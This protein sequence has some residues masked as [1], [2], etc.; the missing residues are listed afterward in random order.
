MANPTS[1]L[2]KSTSRALPWSA[3]SSEVHVLFSS[4]GDSSRPQQTNRHQHA[5]WQVEIVLRGPFRLCT[6]DRRADLTDGDV[7]FVPPFATHDYRYPNQRVRWV[8]LRAVF[9]T[10]QPDTAV[11]ILKGDGAVKGL[12]RTL[13]EVL[14]PGH[15]VPQGRGRAVA[16]RCLAALF[17]YAF[18]PVDSEEDERGDDRV[19]DAVRVYVGEHAHR[20]LTVAEVAAAVGYSPSYLAARYRRQAGTSLKKAI[21]AARAAAAR[22]LLLYSDRTVT[23]IAEA[24]GFVDLYAFSRFFRRTNGA[25]PRDFRRAASATPSTPPPGKRLARRTTVG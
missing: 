18:L 21:D 9:S 14:P 5:H 12:L 7:A 15:G 4:R 10:R 11:T 24:L 8:T 23:Q 19:L 20:R 3:R 22:H 25:A 13:C 16:E 2:S 1:E 6:D 17:S